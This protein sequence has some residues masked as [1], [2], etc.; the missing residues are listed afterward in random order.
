MKEPWHW[1]VIWME[2]TIILL[3]MTIRV[4]LVNMSLVQITQMI[5]YIQKMKRMVGLGLMK[6]HVAQI[7]RDLRDLVETTWI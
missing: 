5:K 1:I 3:K 4:L 7:Y 2:K 6:I